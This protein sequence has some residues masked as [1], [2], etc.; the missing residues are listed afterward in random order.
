MAM[1]VRQHAVTGIGVEEAGTPAPAGTKA[2]TDDK[3]EAVFPDPGYIQLSLLAIVAGALGGYG[4]H[5][6]SKVTF[7]P[8]EGVGIFALFYIV[9]QAI[10]RLLE[11]FAPHAGKATPT[12]ETTLSETTTQQ[13]QL[14]AKAKLEEAVAKALNEPSDDNDKKAANAKRTVDQIRANLNILLFG[15][16]ALLA[17]LVMG[18]LKADLLRTVGVSGAGA[19]IGIVITGLVVG[20]GTKPLH[21]LIGYIEKKKETQEDPAGT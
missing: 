15:L 16:S 21:D 8:P 3:T 12:G 6:V 5:E 20:A 9:A 13:N 1:F 7:D 11:W 10:E 18:F 2:A 17:M 19:F 14:K 4:L